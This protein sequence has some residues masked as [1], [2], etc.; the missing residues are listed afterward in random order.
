MY[1]Q[2]S[3]PSCYLEDASIL[4]HKE[5]PR[6]RT[7]PCKAESEGCETG[8]NKQQLYVFVIEFAFVDRVAYIIEETGGSDMDSG[9]LKLT[10][11]PSSQATPIL[12]PWEMRTASLSSSLLPVSAPG[13]S[14]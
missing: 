12:S 11:V 8:K 4:L 1:S 2:V 3:P 14:V 13:C 10:S 9:V 5:F 6:I 7:L